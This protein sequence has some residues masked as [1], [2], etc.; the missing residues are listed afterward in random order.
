MKNNIRRRIWLSSIHR[1]FSFVEPLGL[2]WIVP[3]IST[4]TLSGNEWLAINKPHN[5]SNYSIFINFLTLQTTMKVM[6]HQFI[7]I[8]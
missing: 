6:S 3:V 8:T 1:D 7:I 5:P 4:S 2:G